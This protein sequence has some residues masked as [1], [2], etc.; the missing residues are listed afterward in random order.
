MITSFAI[1]ETALFPVA[2]IML[3]TL[4]FTPTLLLMIVLFGLGGVFYAS[5]T[6]VW[7]VILAR[8]IMGVASLLVVCILQTYVGEMST[9]LDT[10]RGE[11]GKRPFK[12]ILYIFLLFSINGMQVLLLGKYH[13]T[14]TSLYTCSIVFQCYSIN[15]YFTAYINL[16][17]IQGHCLF[18]AVFIT[19]RDTHAAETFHMTYYCLLIMALAMG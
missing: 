14:C 1:F 18:R 8:G 6:E 7:M 3:D 13:C 10:I 11:K 2:T 16:M 15:N 5:A 19:F 4:P 12:P 17:L 9:I